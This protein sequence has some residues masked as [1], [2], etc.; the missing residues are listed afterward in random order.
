MCL[1]FRCEINKKEFI[2]MMEDNKLSDNFKR[3]LAK[4]VD[5]SE[6]DT[7]NNT[8]SGEN[9]SVFAGNFPGRRSVNSVS[10][11]SGVD[12]GKDQNTI[13]NK[14]RIFAMSQNGDN[15]EISRLKDSP[16]IEK[17]NKFKKSASNLSQNEIKDIK[18]RFKD[19]KALYLFP[20]VVLVIVV[21][22]FLMKNYAEQS[23]IRYLEMR[24]PGETMVV[25]NVRPSLVPFG[26]LAEVKNLNDHT[27]FD[28]SAS[29]GYQLSQENSRYSQNTDEENNTG[30]RR[31]S[32]WAW[33][34]K[35]NYNSERNRDAIF[36]VIR[37]IM[38]N[39]YYNE[40]VAS[41]DLENREISSRTLEQTLPVTLTE[42]TGLRLK[43]KYNNKILNVDSFRQ[44][45]QD[46]WTAL[47]GELK[48]RISSIVFESVVLNSGDSASLFSDM[49]YTRKT[50]VETSTT[51]TETSENSQVNRSNK[52]EE[53]LEPTIVASGYTNK[54]FKYQL[55]LSHGTMDI[56][57]STI[58]NGIH[59]IETNRVS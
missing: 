7:Q 14:A 11:K 22:V 56:N 24:Y 49:G 18:N 39:G 33:F 25:S 40:Y 52:K 12:A 16:R 9:N 51:T 53:K 20:I 30:N 48:E 59:L 38:D 28:I 37:P 58:Y 13:V 34:Y 17:V 26:F 45:S 46:L 4:R 57:E 19:R 43:I 41:Y 31:T 3:E 32:S 54:Y 44:V 47:D 36:K 35:D 50:W 42:P 15:K 10:G 55:V 6:T 23:F 8:N 21:A 2:L 1:L 29:L 5:S 27:K